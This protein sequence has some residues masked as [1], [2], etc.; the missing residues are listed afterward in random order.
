MIRLT[1]VI[2]R[3]A[4]LREA[5]IAKILSRHA[6]TALILE[7]LPDGSA[8]FFEAM[9]HLTQIRIAPGCL[10]CTGNLTLRVTLNRLLRQSPDE[11]YISLANDEHLKELQQ[12]LSSP[13][14]DGLLSLT[15][16]IST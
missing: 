13:P 15:E 5:A 8:S 16:T 1:L 14:Y 11:I 2:G 12:F 4:T 10:C 7:G 3:K 6:K 9:P